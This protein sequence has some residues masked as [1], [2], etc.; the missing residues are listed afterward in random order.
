MLEVV[1]AHFKPE[2]L[3]RLDDIVVFEPLGTAEL[4]GIVDMQVAVAARRLA[5][6]RL[7]LRVTDAAREWLALNGFD[8][9]YG[10]RPLRR[11]V[12]SAIGDQLA[13]ALIAGEI[14][15]G[16]E[17]MVDAADEFVGSGEHGLSSPR[18]RP[19]HRTGPPDPQ[20]SGGPR[21]S[22]PP[23]APPRGLVANPGP[24]VHDRGTHGTRAGGRGMDGRARAVLGTAEQGGVPGRGG[25]PTGWNAPP[26]MPHPRMPRPPELERAAPGLGSPP[27]QPYGYAPAPPPR[28]GP[29]PH[30][31]RSARWTVR[32]GLGAFIGSLVLSVIS[33][34]GRRSS[35]GTRISAQ[36]LARL[37]DR[38][39]IGR[40]LVTPPLAERPGG[41][42]ALGVPSS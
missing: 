5:A 28:Y 30:T 35:T 32:A 40:T 12:Q 1:R 34:R 17:V 11:L 41:S 42:P 21:V 15:D 14:R 9:L 22:G 26:R 6:R 36:L 16:D 29:P 7:T 18:L 13:R 31:D 39:R 24:V 25:P 23:A 37:S 8:P 33:T 27:Q 20:G 3:N 38:P 4:T 2:F 19:P 10:A